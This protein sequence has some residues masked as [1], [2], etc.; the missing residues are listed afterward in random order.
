MSIVGV[1]TA[2]DNGN[3]NVGDSGGLAIVNESWDLHIEQQQ[4]SKI[5]ERMV[6]NAYNASNSAYVC[7]V[8]FVTT[9]TDI[10]NV[11]YLS[12]FGNAYSY[13]TIQ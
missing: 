11:M 8:K 4:G 12:V 13:E 3:P 5:A 7:D 6:G 1:C 2:Y 10:G 9:N